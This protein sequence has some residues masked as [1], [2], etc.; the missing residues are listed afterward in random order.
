MNF[1]DGSSRPFRRH[2]GA[3]AS[4]E[5]GTTEVSAS[6]CLRDDLRSALCEGLHADLLLVAEDESEH[7]AHSMMLAARSPIFKAMLEPGKFLEGQKLEE[8]QLRRINVDVRDGKLLNFF[9]DYVYTGRLKE[10]LFMDQYEGLLV[11]AVKYEFSSLIFDCVS[12]LGTFMRIETVCGFLELAGR[13]N[14]KPLKDMVL[15]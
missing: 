9:L 14:C 3:F 4:N 13:L 1:P 8:G 10:D 7:Q 6:Q 5:S 12:A 11:A 2:G 15:E